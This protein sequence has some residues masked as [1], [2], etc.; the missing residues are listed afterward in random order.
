MI[1]HQLSSPNALEQNSLSERDGSTTMDI[2]RCRLNG[3]TLSK[4]LWGKMAATA[5]FLLTPPNTTIDGDASRS[6]DESGIISQF[7]PHFGR[8]RHERNPLGNIFDQPLG[9]MSWIRGKLANHVGDHIA[10]PL[11]SAAMVTSLGTESS[12]TSPAHSLNDPSYQRRER[13]V[14]VRR[15]RSSS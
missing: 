5:V 12:N 11:E 8:G 13:E 14:Q 6:F 9:E 3:A 7:F 10:I 2:A 4:P 15:R 1:I